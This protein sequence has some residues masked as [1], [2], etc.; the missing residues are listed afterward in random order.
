MMT[1]LSSALNAATDLTATIIKIRTITMAIH[2]RIT[3]SR[4]TADKIIITVSKAMKAIR[5]TTALIPTLR[6]RRAVIL[7]IIIRI[8][9]TRRS[10]RACSK[11]AAS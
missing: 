3:V 2:S 11:K 1:A 4:R 8:I 9:T 6:I 7:I 10:I 5:A